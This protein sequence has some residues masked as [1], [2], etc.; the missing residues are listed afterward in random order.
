[1]G[2]DRR[3][4]SVPAPASRSW[5]CAAWQ[6]RA[7]AHW[8]W[9]A[10]VIDPAHREDDPDVSPC[11]RAAQVPLPWLLPSAQRCLR[12]QDARCP[13]CAPTPRTTSSPPP[14]I[15]FTRSPPPTPY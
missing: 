11:L 4:L 2:R 10:F 13:R 14:L 15:F 7:S 3:Y 5:M 6:R 9:V 1:M 8:S 12:S